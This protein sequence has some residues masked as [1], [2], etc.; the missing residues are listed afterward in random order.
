MHFCQYI[1]V[2][3]VVKCPIFIVGVDVGIDIVA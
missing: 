3:S 1:A 2:I